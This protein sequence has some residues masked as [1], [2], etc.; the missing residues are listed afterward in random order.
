MEQST[1]DVEQLL[2]RLLHRHF[3]PRRLAECAAQ[4]ITTQHAS[5]LLQRCMKL[6]VSP[7]YNGIAEQVSS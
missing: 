6:Y 2:A 3:D 5:V 7:E 4:K 1:G